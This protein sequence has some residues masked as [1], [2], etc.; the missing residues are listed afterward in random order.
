MKLKNSNCDETQKTQLVLKL[1]NSNVRVCKFVCLFVCVCAT[2]T[3]AGDHTR[4]HHVHDLV[5]E[6]LQVVPFDFHL[7]QSLHRRLQFGDGECM[8][9]GVRQGV[10]MCSDG[11]RFRFRVLGFG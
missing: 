7:Q 10:V 2:L 11:W 1:K 9:S 3:T 8:R 5:D 6:G 4:T